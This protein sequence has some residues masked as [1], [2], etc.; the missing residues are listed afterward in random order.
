MN[1]KKRLIKIQNKNE[2]NYLPGIAGAFGTGGG[3]GGMTEIS[4]TKSIKILLV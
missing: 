4:K 3:G 2:F 1:D